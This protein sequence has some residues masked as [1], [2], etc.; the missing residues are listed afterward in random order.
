MASLSQDQLERFFHGLRELERET[1]LTIIDTA[2]GMADNVRHFIIAAPETILIT[3]P[4]PT[5]ITDAYAMIKVITRHHLKP[6]IHLVVN[7]ARNEAEAISTAKA[8]SLAAREFLK[9]ELNHLGYLP[10][11]ANIGVATRRQEPFVIAFPQSAATHHL[12]AITR[13]VINVSGEAVGLEEYFRRLSEAPG[14]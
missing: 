7:M 8:I 6:N 14:K 9:I 4:E 13:R 10:Y 3:T 2:A 5:A 12:L 1:D 11:D